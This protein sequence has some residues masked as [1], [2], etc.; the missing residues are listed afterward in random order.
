MLAFV[1]NSTQPVRPVSM[2]F[3]ISPI[4]VGHTFTTQW[5]HPA[6]QICLDTNLQNAEKKSSMISYLITDLN[7]VTLKGIW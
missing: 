5:L 7:H 6:K 3:K 1:N 2:L 4:S